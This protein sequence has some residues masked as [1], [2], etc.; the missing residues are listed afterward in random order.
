MNTT[1]T[2]EMLARV[3]D[4]FGALAD[5]ARLRMMIRLSQGEA[6]VNDLAEAAGVS[7]PSA[8][9]HLS[10]LRQANLVRTRRVGAMALCSIRDESLLQVC[11]IVCGSVCD[12][13]AEESRAVGLETAPKGRPVFRR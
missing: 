5:T 3:A 12:A 11:D 6:S 13:V 4:L 10:V 9:K 8:S 2:P 7:Q 1:P